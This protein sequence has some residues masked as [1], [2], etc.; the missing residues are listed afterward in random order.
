MKGEDRRRS[1]TGS[2]SWRADAVVALVV[3]SGIAILWS[4]PL[5]SRIAGAIPG[6]DGDIWSYVWA[7]GLARLAVWNGFNPFHT[8]QIFFPLGGATQLL[9]GTALPSFASI[10]LQLAFGL[11]PAFN[12]VY[13]AASAL[14]GLGMYL[15]ACDVLGDARGGSSR[16]AVQAAALVSAL[17]FAFGALRSGYGL[18][19][20]NLFHTEFIP[21]YILS[22]RHVTRKRQL[23]HAALAGL[24]LALNAYVDFQIA[25][26]LVVLTA[27]WAGWDVLTQGREWTR[28]DRRALAVR[29]A[30]MVAV[31][32]GLAL[33]MLGFLLNDFA[34]E[35]GNYIRVYPLRYSADRSYDLLS[36]VLPNA[37]STLYG[38]LPTP[39]V[40]GVN[41][42][43]AT[44]DES[45]MSPDRQAFLGFTTMALALVGIAAYRR[46][47]G[48]WIAVT[49]FFAILALGP[50]LHIAGSVTPVPLP[51]ALI[52][53]IPILNHIR[54]PMRY[55][56]M[57]SFGT[58]LLAGGGAL[59]LATR[60]AW[61][62]V[63]AAMLIALEAAV[64][65]YPTLAVSVPPVYEQVARDV[66]D[67]AV[68]EI[69]S[70]N[71]RAA[72]RNEMYQAFHGKR[73]LRAYTN[74][75]APDV[76]DFFN[77]R[78]TPVLVRSLR[79][80]EGADSGALSADDLRQDRAI[81]PQTLAFFG[82]RY[83][84]LHLDE[85]DATRAAA[86]D[87]YLR[88]V[89]GA[90]TFYSDGMVTAYRFPP[91]PPSVAVSQL[92]FGADEGLMYLG[93][94][95]QTEPR[96]DVDGEQGRYMMGDRAEVYLPPGTT[97]DVALT[98]YSPEAG[99]QVR[100]QSIGRET[101]LEL[102]Q[103]WKTYSVRL[104]AGAGKLSLRTNRREGADRIAMAAIEVHGQ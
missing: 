43:L 83:A 98:L 20:T 11:I 26:F 76:A 59:A 25:A 66:G 29:W 13:L 73:I 10:P 22:L 54:I 30:A 35:G 90:S 6:V 81:A 51:F 18:A 84:V 79:A 14:T 28:R 15:L 17:A 8:E 5:A 82:I 64:L 93:R 91:A 41:A 100:V 80:L 70:F 95:W 88:G 31:A 33:P 7:M 72:A 40:N 53:N 86:I 34:I 97:G 65:P 101:L 57:V 42:S 3:F 62:V 9:W 19:F 102:E 16:R 45:E 104:G 23:K 56:L 71:W 37:R 89:L 38:G 75:I 44:P 78:Q 36:F 60:R 39:R 4:W 94:G 2:A 92:T 58:A 46:A 50:V 63:P 99:R 68:L 12:L 1:S 24:F 77:L 85:L 21:F 32:G 67:F 49:V 27:L 74:R 96:A 47:L 55:G 52:N 87:E 61:L 103:G 69:P 48:F